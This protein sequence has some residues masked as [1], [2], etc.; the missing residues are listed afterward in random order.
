M[1]HYFE[2][3]PSLSSKEFTFKTTI[4]NI[5]F[6]FY[7]DRGVFSKNS[8]DF[9]T[10]LLL[11]QI[12][13]S[14]K[15]RVLDFGCGYGP[16]GIYVKKI[17]HAHVDMIDINKRSL[18]LASKNA[19]AN[20]VS[21]HIFESDIYENIKEKYDFILTNPPIRVGKKILYDILLGAYDHLKEEGILLFV[22][23]KDQGAKSVLRDLSKRYKTCV[24][25]KDKG[26]FVI[27]CTKILTS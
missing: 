19:K 9:G 13:F 8:L 1:S 26:F 14:I 3:D 10:K 20:H 4:K 18:H 16:I 22:I 17:S 5:P 11:E 25:A 6:L 7:S 15:G 24:L 2:N 21:V 23:H 27:K 12:D